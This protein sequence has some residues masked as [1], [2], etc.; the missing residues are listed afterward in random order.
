MSGSGAMGQTMGN[1]AQG[2]TSS[3]RGTMQGQEMTQAMTPMVQQTDDVILRMQEMMKG[4]MSH[5]DMGKMSQV[6]N[7]MSK[8]L[9]DISRA[10]DKGKVSDKQ[11]QTM[12]DRVA[13]M[14]T[15]LDSMKQ[16]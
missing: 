13:Q 11:L 6:V 14:K 3:G 8:Q 5:E 10:M 16:R 9:S 4:G 15:T 2:T 12:Q 1:A 7:N